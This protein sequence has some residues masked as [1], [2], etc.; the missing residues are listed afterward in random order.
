MRGKRRVQRFSAVIRCSL[1]CRRPRVILVAEQ[2]QIPDD[3]RN[4]LGDLGNVWFSAV[5]ADNGTS[6]R[7]ELSAEGG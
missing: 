2:P 1:V 4:I 3:C 5:Y 6:A 7:Y